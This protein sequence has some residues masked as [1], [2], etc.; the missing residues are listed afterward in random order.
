MESEIVVNII[1]QLNALWEPVKIVALLIGYLLVGFGLFWF[2]L[3]SDKSRGVSP[4]S[5]LMMIAAG[6]ILVSLDSFLQIS[7]YSLFEQSS[8]LD[9]LGYSDKQASGTWEKFSVLGFAVFKFLG[10][11]AGIKGIYTM[12][13]MTKSQQQSVF[14]VILYLFLAVVG[15]NFPHFLDI[16]GTSLGG[17][18]ESSIDKALQAANV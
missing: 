5:C 12:Y 6:L 14:T 15:L 11:I 9:A 4:Y 1:E 18:V 2:A 7:S 16:I 3:S 13:S 10:L 17:V 8:N